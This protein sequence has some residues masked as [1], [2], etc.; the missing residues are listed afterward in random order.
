[1]KNSFPESVGLGN[2][3]KT[4]RNQCTVSVVD[5]YFHGSLHLKKH[6]VFVL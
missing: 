5:L 1:M 6:T 3:G 2:L 4:N